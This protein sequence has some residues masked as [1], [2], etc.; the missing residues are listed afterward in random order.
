MRSFFVILISWLGLSVPAHS[1]PPPAEI[2]GTLPAIYD[3]AISPDGKQ[4]AMIENFKGMYIIQII[5]LDGR[6]D[7][8]NPIGLGKGVKPIGITWANPNRVL[9]S[10]W[11]SEK[12]RTTPITVGYIYTLDT[13]DMKGKILVKPKDMF[14]QFN[15]V[16][17]DYL[18][19]DPD[20][21][22]MSFSET[23]NTHP[24]DL[25]KINVKT[26]RGTVIKRAL[27][28]VQYWQTDLRGEPRIGQGLKDKSTEEW[29]LRIR[30]AEGKKWMTANDF[31]G[32]RA[33]ADIHGFTGNP[34]E[35]IIESYQGKDTKGLYIYDLQ[36][37]KITRKLFHND[38]YDASGVILSQDG[39]KVIGATYVADVTERELFDDYS[40]ALDRVRKKFAGS[41]V[42]FIDRSA[43]GNL[44]LF[45]V[46]NP[47]DP[48]GI[49]II[50]GA[51]DDIARL[52]GLYK[53][54]SADNLGE[55]ISVS[56]KA[57][58]GV[59]IPA[60]V[61]LPPA[62]TETSMIKNLPFIIL[63]HGGPYSRDT[64]RFD[65]LAQFFAT[66]GYGV[67]QMNFR[68]SEGYGKTFKDSG[69]D[70]WVVMQEDVED[71][72]KWLMSKGYADPNR[73]CIAGWSYGGYAAL[74][75]ALKNPDLYACAVSMAGVTDLKD[76]INDIK[77]YQFGR[78]SARNFVLK[79]FDSKDDIRA[80]SPVKLAADL[81]VP[82]FLAHGTA[83]QRV[84]F[85]QYKR[86]KSALKK[87][88]AKVTF[89]DFK[90]EDH[91]LSNQENRQR[92]F[93]GMEKFLEETVGPSE[94]AN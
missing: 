25:R 60:Y 79:G 94:F 52:G 73:T 89:M 43:D 51:K 93:K 34:N 86:M 59:K 10:L 22:L 81:T 5:A 55:V 44:T 90:G 63:P 62:V 38:K 65:Y 88:P 30:E 29:V 92:F 6:S 15:H 54:L 85:D 68:G 78:I 84:H 67:L 57:R 58:D 49:Y 24:P 11:Q 40:S 74:M 80:N 14:R 70:N 87:S 36:A 72:A 82:L 21:I 17:V 50:D 28:D 8:R 9:V 91:F 16:V 77:K 18:E 19:D 13:V 35:M 39:G 46:S 26:G 41:T 2:F 45:K 12:L 47:S 23:S 32:L 61:T 20:H 64:K 75:G 1:A 66:R 83:D 37:K 3:A 31:P 7:D 53:G 27:S 56:Y 42:D 76:M 71:G 33:D 48:G 4:I 69:R